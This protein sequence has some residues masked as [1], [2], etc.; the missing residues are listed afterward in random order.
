[1][2]FTTT[3]SPRQ[4]FR[5]RHSACRVVHQLKVSNCASLARLQFGH[6]ATLSLVILSQLDNPIDHPLL[7]IHQLLQAATSIAN[8][9]SRTSAIQSL[10]MTPKLFWSPI[11]CA[12]MS[13]HVLKDVQKLPQ[14]TG[15][16]RWLGVGCK[17]LDSRVPVPQNSLREKLSP[18]LWFWQAS[19]QY[20]IYRARRL[21][22]IVHN[23][24]VD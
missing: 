6:N 9:L 19:T 15:L 3:L 22:Y 12:I 21:R 24:Q 14:S 13:C 1:M 7:L 18:L 23:T 11:W 10:P 4:K 2:I 8:L 17:F 20:I 5:T 16:A